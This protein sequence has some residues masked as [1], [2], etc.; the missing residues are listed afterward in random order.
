[1]T[2]SVVSSILNSGH[3][4]VSNVLVLRKRGLVQACCFNASSMM[5]CKTLGTEDAK[6]VVP[7]MHTSD[8]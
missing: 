2:Q 6:L 5:F 4:V 1:M 3:S 7:L 8:S